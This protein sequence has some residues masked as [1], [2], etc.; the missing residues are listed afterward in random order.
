MNPTTSD[1]RVSQNE[2]TRDIWLKS[3]VQYWK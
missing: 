3:L 1:S 2:K